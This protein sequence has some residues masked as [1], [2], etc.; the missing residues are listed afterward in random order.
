MKKITPILVVDAIE[1]S[2]VLWV[3]RLGF[4][5]TAEVPDGDRLGFVILSRDPLE[6]MYQTRA[7]IEKE[8]KKDG[9]PAVMTPSGGASVLYFEVSDFE[10]IRKRV[11]GLDVVL[12]YRETSYGARELWLR[13]PGGHFIGFA[14][15]KQSPGGRF[16]GRAS[17]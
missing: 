6:V 9:L 5:K 11:Q 4:E 16:F 8:I 3:D 1:P 7:S 15:M 13:E 2:L 14:A 17:S 12:P 10:D